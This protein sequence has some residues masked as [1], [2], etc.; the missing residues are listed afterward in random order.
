MLWPGSW[1]S[2]SMHRE[3]RATLRVDWCG[4]VGASPKESNSA[5]WRQSCSFRK[6]AP[7]P[8]HRT[9]SRGPYPTWTTCPSTVSS[10]GRSS[11]PC[12]SSVGVHALPR[13]CC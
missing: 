8:T 4:R 13:L 9:S 6:I 12:A 5:Q 7:P 3:S 11:A 1:L 10:R 2:L